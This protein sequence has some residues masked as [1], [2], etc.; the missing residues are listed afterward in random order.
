MMKIGILQTGRTP[1]ELREKHGDYDDL[2][3]RLLA[4]R[5]FEFET[6]PVLDG[7]FPASP[8]AAEGWL[9]TGS[10]FGSYDPH[11][12]IAPLEDFLR[13]TYQT[14]VPMVG[15]CFGHQIL[16]QA[17]GGKVEKY[18]GGWSVGA[19]DYQMAGEPQ[20]LTIMAWHQ[21]QIVR[22]PPGAK[23]TGVSQN[24]KYAMLSYGN[25][26]ISVQPHPEFT[27][28]FM[29]DLIEARR[30]VLPPK[31]AESAISTLNRKLTSSRLADQFEGFFKDNRNMSR[32]ALGAAR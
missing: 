26:A 30:D 5:G 1:P 18:G 32:K 31:V 10:R 13:R 19:L 24:C 29:A 16:A 22:I 14:G 11:D 17:L 6:W 20:D 21:D 4:G 7:I 28:P 9:I 15:V 2:Y 27:A 25:R 3:K 8:E 23:V 12:W